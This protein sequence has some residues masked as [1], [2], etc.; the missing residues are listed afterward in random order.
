M[1]AIQKWRV[2][3]L[4]LGSV[5]ALLL[6][7]T[8]ALGQQ[9]RPGSIPL[10]SFEPENASGGAYQLVSVAWEVSGLSSGGDYR[11]QGPAA[12]G[13]RGSGCCCTYLPLTL[14]NTP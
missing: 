6:L 8:A 10:Y 12:P 5:V 2:W 3:V 13:L 4:L 1:S 11:L 7:S 9:S 14:R